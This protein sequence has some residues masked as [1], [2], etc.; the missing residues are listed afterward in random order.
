MFNSKIWI[1]MGIIITLVLGFSL[2]MI[3]DRTITSKHKDWLT[4]EITEERLLAR[5]SRK[6]DLTRPQI[7]AIGGILRIEAAKLK[8]AG[9]QFRNNLKGIKEET[10]EKIKPH[11]TP[12]QQEKYTKLVESHKRRWER[13]CP[14]NQKSCQL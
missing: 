5:L 12:I 11:L 6:L 8:E 10:M 9:D 2:G 14:P 3:I 4:K 7:Q 1:I 13:V